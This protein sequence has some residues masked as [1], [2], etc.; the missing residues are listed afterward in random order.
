MGVQIGCSVPASLVEAAAGMGYAFVELRVDE[1]VDDTRPGGFAEIERAVARAGIPARTF[2]YFV[3]P[4]L[5]VVGPEVDREAL[6]RHVA[7]AAERAAAIGGEAFVFG[8]GG[9]RRVP[10]GFPR[11]R[12]AAQVREAA[13]IAADEAWRRG[14]RIALEP[15]SRVEANLLHTVE[16]AVAWVA[17][18]DH[19]ALG[20]TADS[21]HM[22]MEGEPQRHLLLAG[23]HLLHVQVC[24]AGRLPPG[25]HG[26]DLR[27]F[28]IDLNAI[29]YAGT[30]A[31]ECAF[32]SFHEE[33]PPALAYVRDVARTTGDLVVVG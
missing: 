22:H 31:I 15:M 28:F 3:P 17:E 23:A 4:T 29:G 21:Y 14:I 12:A 19:E 7:R 2:N 11:E 16:D 18:L 8:S 9:A 6:R 1:I 27:G 24:D 5:P 30:V 20:L 13:C 33:G 25:G 26:L 10:P 32:R